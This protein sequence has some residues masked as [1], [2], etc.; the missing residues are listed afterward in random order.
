MGTTH[1]NA[2]GRAES[3]IHK[4]CHSSATCSCGE[5]ISPLKSSGRRTSLELSVARKYR[6]GALGAS[7]LTTSSIP[8][9]HGGVIT[10]SVENE[11]RHSSLQTAPSA[12]AQ[13][14]FVARIGC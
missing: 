1:Q 2:H 3:V 10:P 8:S 7:R 6:S 14:D 13:M 5:R 11:L 9:I 4:R 12:L